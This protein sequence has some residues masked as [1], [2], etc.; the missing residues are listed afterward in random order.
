MIR[1]NV[2]GLCRIISE[3][4]GKMLG[5]SDLYDMNMMVHLGGLINK[6]LRETT[7]MNVSVHANN[8]LSTLTWSDRHRRPG[9]YIPSRKAL[10]TRT[11]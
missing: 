1:E 5:A 10:Q 4:L 6:S 2:G 11:V 7:V 9:K 3:K 8:T